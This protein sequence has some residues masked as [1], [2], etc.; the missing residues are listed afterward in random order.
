M[1]IHWKGWALH[2]H[3]A[4][5][6]CFFVWG[7]W[8]LTDSSLSCS[9]N[10]SLHAGIHYFQHYLSMACCM[11]KSWRVPLQSYGFLISFKGSLIVWSNLCHL[12]LWLS[13]I[14]S[15]FTRI[16]G[17]LNW[18]RSGGCHH[19][20][21][22]ELLFSKIKAYVHHDRTLGWDPNDNDNDVYVY[23]H[24]LAPARSLI[25]WNYMDL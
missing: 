19:I 10:L 23:V 7:K 16:H 12:A 14:M 4:M 11:Q 8:Y 9:R 25:T 6:Q 18:L 5:C 20:N 3:Q 24:H 22:I 15:R 1:A 2:G 21:P 17:L 13:W